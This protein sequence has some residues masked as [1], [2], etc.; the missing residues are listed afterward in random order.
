MCRANILQ[1]RLTALTA[2]E[3]LYQLSH[4][5]LIG[6]YFWLKGLCYCFTLH[7]IVNGRTLEA[8]CCQ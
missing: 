8:D 6:Q 5:I 7:H 2:T 1:H 4:Q 3:G